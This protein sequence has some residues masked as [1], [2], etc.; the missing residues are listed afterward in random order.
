MNWDPDYT[1]L[2]S[3]LTLIDQVRGRPSGLRGTNCL[4]L[5]SYFKKKSDA[6]VRLCMNGSCV[7]GFGGQ[8]RAVWSPIQLPHPVFSRAKSQTLDGKAFLLCG[9]LCIGVH[10]GGRDRH[11]CSFLHRRPRSSKP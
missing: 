7:L 4:G 6:T 1:C 8:D 11:A 3:Q 9:S 2:T 10:S 5:D